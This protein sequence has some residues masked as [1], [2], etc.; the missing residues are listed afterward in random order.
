[1]IQID[2]GIPVPERKDSTGRPETRPWS[3]ME[4]GD[5]FFEAS[6]KKNINIPMKYRLRAKW[7]TR[8]VTENGVR[9]CRVWRIA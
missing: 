8:I 2:K 7:K 6:D 3:E 9:G 1:M 5:S 4:P